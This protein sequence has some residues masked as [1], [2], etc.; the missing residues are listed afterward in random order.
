MQG[1]IDCSRFLCDQVPDTYGADSEVSY[2][3]DIDTH[4][5]EISELEV[6]ISDE[7]REACQIMVDPLI[8]SDKLG[9]DLFLAAKHIVQFNH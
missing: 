5:I 1:C 8:N 2:S 3:P 9:I 6:Q 7:E 4:G